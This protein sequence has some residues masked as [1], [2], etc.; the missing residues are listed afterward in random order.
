MSIKTKITLAGTIITTVLIFAYVSLRSGVIEKEYVKTLIP[1]SDRIAYHLKNFEKEKELRDK[2]LPG[3][4]ETITRK[5]QP[6]AVLAIAD[7]TGTLV[8]AGKNGRYIEN[9]AAFDAIINSF[10]RGDFKARGGE[11]FI[12]RY[13]NQTKYY[14]FEKEVS[15]GRMLILFPYKLQGKLLIKLL[16]ELLLIAILSVI[17][18][19]AF[20]LYLQR[21][22]RVP[23]EAHYKVVPLAPKKTETPR[24]GDTIA[25]RI[26]R[27]AAESLHRQ[28]FELFSYLAA[29]YSPGSI[30]LYVIGRTSSAMEKLYEMKGKTFIKIDAAGYEA[31]DIDGEI[32]EELGKSSIMVLQA[33][34]KLVIPVVYRNALMAAVQLD[35]AAGFRGPEINDIKMNSQK[36][37]QVVSEYLLLND[38]VLDAG[39]GLYSKA[40]FGIKYDEMLSQSE[41][42][43]TALGVLVISIFGHDS[44]LSDTRKDLALKSVCRR[45][46]DFTRENAVFGRYDDWIAVLFPESTQDET[47]ALALRLQEELSDLQI[48][49]DRKHTLNITPFIGIA[50]SSE[51]DKGGPL[52]TALANLGYMLS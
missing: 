10:T 47:A 52:E 6:I 7:K 25:G 28:V 51:K 31:M 36:I 8:A 9:T 38:V 34:R 17:F 3:F 27:N 11:P 14:V 44:G 4:L 20:Y 45:L 18:T 41:S 30:S 13:Y 22:G 39:T 46:A 5:Y 35:R 19:T 42:L 48:K 21:S 24:D 1:L 29:A 50:S 26:S 12:I 23:E 49:L 43:G 2:N 33:G 32:G 15:E 16:L 37:T 40:Y